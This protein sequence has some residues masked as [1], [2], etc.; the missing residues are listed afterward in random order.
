[1]MR[2]EFLRWTKK[3]SAKNTGE[4]KYKYLLFKPPKTNAK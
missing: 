4:N 1:M 3:S 2:S